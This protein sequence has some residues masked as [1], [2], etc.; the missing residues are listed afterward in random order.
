MIIINDTHLGV[1]RV[2]GTTPQSREDL[3][4]YVFAEFDRLLDTTDN[5]NDLVIL[6]DLFDSFDCDARDWLEAYRLLTAWCAYNSFH[7]LYLVAGNHD[8]SAKANRVSSFET[9]AAVLKGQFRNVKVIGIDETLTADGYIHLVAHHRNQE[10]FDLTLAKVLE[11]CERGDY[12][13]LHANYDNKFAEQ[14]DHSLNVSAEQAYMFNKKG[15]ML[16]FAHEHKYK[17]ERFPHEVDE[18]FGSVVVLGCQYPTSISDCT[19]E[20]EKFYWSVD[21][22]KLVPHRFWE[23][24]DNYAELDWRSLPQ[25]SPAKFIRVVG[26]AVNAEAA[27]VIDAIHR[28]RQKS[29]AF[30]ITNA[31]KIEGIADIESLPEAFEAS[32][33]F[34]VME[35]VYGQLNEAEAEVIRKITEGLE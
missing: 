1:N 28:F 34:D 10:L 16:L 19:G 27:Q 29:N 24:K 30:V 20:T 8:T 12:V 17:I 6:G 4:N 9:M 11:D 2:S 35:F 26:D 23:A 22:G 14:A 18:H 25:D 15:V 32:R 21:N 7:T 13:L 3:R 33:K 5:D 31:V